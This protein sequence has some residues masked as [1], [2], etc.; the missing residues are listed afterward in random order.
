MIPKTD[1]PCITTWIARP[2]GLNSAMLLIARPNSALSFLAQESFYVQGILNETNVQDTSFLD[3]KHKHM[4]KTRAPPDKV[5][6]LYRLL[7]IEFHFFTSRIDL[8]ALSLF[9]SWS[10]LIFLEGMGPF[11]MSGR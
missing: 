1:F 9:G 4:M 7:P 5:R 8:Q 10:Y 2:F 11:K 6:V 3:C